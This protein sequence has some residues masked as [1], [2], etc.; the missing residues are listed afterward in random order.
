M[1]KGPAHFHSN[2]F[3]ILFLNKERFGWVFL[4]GVFF[5]FSFF[6]L[7]PF[8]GGGIDSILYCKLRG[9]VARGFSPDTHHV[10]FCTIGVPDLILLKPTPSA[11]FFQIYSKTRL[12]G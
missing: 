9:E 7:L 3:S 5:F 10:T 8:S 6:L 11:V 1:R 4:V 2:T 12:K